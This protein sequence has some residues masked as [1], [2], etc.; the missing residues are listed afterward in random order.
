MSGNLNV[1]L[2]ASCVVLREGVVLM[3]REK[4]S[5]GNLKYNLPGGGVEM[6][7]TPMEAAM[8]EVKEETELTVEIGRF[9]QATVN[10]W[11]KKDSILFYFEGHI[12][13]QYDLVAENGLELKWMNR[14][15]VSA[16]DD[17]NFIFGVRDAVMKVF[18]SSATDTEI[19]LVRKFGEKV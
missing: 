16:L 6:G 13:G 3:T 8:R 4:D 15:E 19:F 17:S 14:E 5:E 10:V 12:S 18:D 2:Y 9:L 11:S 1:T 7:E